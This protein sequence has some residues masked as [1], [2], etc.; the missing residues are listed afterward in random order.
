MRSCSAHWQ[1]INICEMNTIFWNYSLSLKKKYLECFQLALP[2]RLFIIIYLVRFKPKKNYDSFNR[3]TQTLVFK[4]SLKQKGC[5][6]FEEL[7]TFLYSM[8]LILKICDEK[9]LKEAAQADGIEWATIQFTSQSLTVVRDQHLWVNTF[10]HTHMHMFM[11]S[12]AI[13]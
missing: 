12:W 5:K 1:K 11:H 9:L 13:L 7:V 2:S 10:C 3:I 8:L 6:M 4:F